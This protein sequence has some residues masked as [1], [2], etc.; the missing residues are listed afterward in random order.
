[1]I[2]R[3]IVT[4]GILA[5]IG[6][7]AAGTATAQTSGTPVRIGVIGDFSGPYIDNIGMPFFSAAQLAAEQFGGTVLGRPIEVIYA[8]D[9][10]K[11]DVSLGI[12][13]RWLDNEDVSA[14]ITGSTSAIALGLSS[15]TNEKNKVLVLAGSGNSDV[16]GKL[17]N[18]TTFQFGF[19]TYSLPKSAV[20]A[21]VKSG[22]DTWFIIGQDYAFGHQLE[23]TAR[24][25]IGEAGGK[26]LG[27]VRHPLNNAD[28]SSFLLQAQAS[29]A[30]AIAIANGGADLTNLAKQARE[31]GIGSGNQV[32][33]PLAAFYPQVKSLGPDVAQGMLFS[34]YFYWNYDD[35]TRAWSKKQMEK[36]AGKVP[37]VQQA[38][39]YSSVLHYLKAVEKAGTTDGGKV[40]E[41]MKSMR[42][43]DDLLTDVE[44]RQDGQLMR[45]IYLA[46]A[47]APADI[48]DPNDIMK[49]V[50]VVPAEAGMR[51]LE[52][53]AC[54]LVKS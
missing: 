54:P 39:S 46:Q 50:Q 9:A 12:A 19:D 13:R 45:P 22:L 4:S 49:I 11:A 23:A 8:D 27:S 38:A 51:T 6:A 10:T 35:R 29:G 17:C 5:T 43:N 33:V 16:T 1:M 26:V 53:G 47:K 24:K 36:A 48:Q 32:L 28:F 37:D 15:L 2:N 41:A 42:V 20:V 21:A 34:S 25:Y 40:A 44:V 7:M 52:V 31:F 3:R 18:N 30:K 14:I